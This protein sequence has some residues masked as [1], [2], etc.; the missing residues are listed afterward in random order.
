M[1]DG[2][3]SARA[4]IEITGED[5]ISFLQSIITQDV[6]LLAT[7]PLLFAAILNPQGKLAH[8]FFLFAHQEAIILDTPDIQKEA[9]LKRLTMYKLRA[10][11]SLRDV[12]GEWHVGYLERGGFADPRHADMP[13]RLYHA[14]RTTHHAPPLS[15]ETYHQARLALGIPESPFDV[16]D[17]TAMDL[18]YDLLHAIS[19]TKG[20]YVG[21]EVTA[22]MHHKQIAR[23]GFYIVEG[24]TALPAPGAEIKAGDTKVGTLRGAIGSKGLALLKFE[25]MEA[26]IDRNI[27]LTVDSQPIQA[28]APAWLAPKLAQFHAT[29][30]NQ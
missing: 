28:K 23:R 1:S 22:R 26:A 14:P 7:S 4:F 19:F 27:P 16:M 2:F 21:Q 3:D 11:I 15:I 10:K 12:S 25:E 6:T 20:C 30:E 5:R 9:L 29:R 18:G 24:D 17:D 8:D 13:H